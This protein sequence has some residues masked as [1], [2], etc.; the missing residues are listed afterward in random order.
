[1]SASKHQFI[2][3]HG[4]LVLV[5]DGRKSLLFQNAG[6]PAAPRLQ[7]L[8]QRDAPPNPPTHSQGTDRPGRVDLHQGRRSAMDQTDWHDAAERAFAEEVAKRTDAAMSQ[9][10]APSL[11]IF[12]PPRTLSALRASLSAAT[13]AAVAGEAAVDLTKHTVAEIESRLAMRK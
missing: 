13:Q 9:H 1:M 3:T 6:T 10:A 12:A 7:L 5:T 8:E 2:A 11:V 4:G